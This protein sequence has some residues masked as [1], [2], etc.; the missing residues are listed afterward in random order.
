MNSPHVDILSLPQQGARVLSFWRTG[1]LLGLTWIQEI[2]LL[3]DSP[4]EFVTI[5]VLFHIYLSVFVINKRLNI[6]RGI[7]VP[8]M[9]ERDDDLLFQE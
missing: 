5:N 4:N 9:W 3:G 7:A 1:A 8:R 2:I 6:A